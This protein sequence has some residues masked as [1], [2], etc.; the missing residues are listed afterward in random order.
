[1]SEDA[2]TPSAASSD[3]SADGGVPLRWLSDLVTTDGY[4][5]YVTDPG[6]GGDDAYPVERRHDAVTRVGR[7]SQAASCGDFPWRSWSA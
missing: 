5:N 1:M 3:A 2:G 6:D 4:F 7:S